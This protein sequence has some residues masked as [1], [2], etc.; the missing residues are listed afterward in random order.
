MPK[1]YRQNKKRIDPRYFLNET[2][3][4]DENINEIDLD[5][6]SD[7]EYQYNQ[8]KEYEK[9]TEQGYTDKQK[10]DMET[11]LEFKVMQPE[12]DEVLSQDDQIKFA[13]VMNASMN[14]DLSPEQIKELI[15]ATDDDNLD[16]LKK[17]VSKIAGSGQQGTGAGIDLSKVDRDRDGKISADQLA[18][19][20]N[21]I[22]K[23]QA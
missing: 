12:R 6:A 3:N 1:F 20:A 5:Y 14:G 8:A 11:S 9:K 16:N 2:T 13:D 15:L 10:E 19:I 18:N 17:V 23:N 7:L 22:K 21:A 4:R